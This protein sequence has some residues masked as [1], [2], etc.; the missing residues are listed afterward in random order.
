MAARP[1]ILVVGTRNPKKCRE[2]QDALAGLA[3]EVRTLADF[4]PVPPAEETGQTFEA[5]AAA[6]ALHY[7]RATGHWCLADDSGIEVP[8]LGDRP[9]ILSARWGGQPLSD[10]RNNHKLLDE[11][12][13]VPRDRWQARYVCVAVVAAPDGRVLAGARGTC[14]GVVTDRPAGSGGFGY[15]PLFYLPEMDCTMAQ[16]SP[17][18]KHAISH[19]GRALRALRERLERLL[20][21]GS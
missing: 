3:L 18:R 7:A 11:L 9:G 14:E 20:A 10:R 8:A 16:L 15:D 1:E 4:E 12:K 21:E 5:N 6:K 13:A 17:D 19:R 2:I